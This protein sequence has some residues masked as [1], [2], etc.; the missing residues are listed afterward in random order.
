MNAVEEV[1]MDAVEE[2]TQVGI[3]ENASEVV[4]DVA[5]GESCPQ[6]DGG[7]CI[8]GQGH[9]QPHRCNKCSYMWG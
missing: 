2:L 1:T 3:A 5:C 7:Y 4:A 8:Q 6:N 9:T